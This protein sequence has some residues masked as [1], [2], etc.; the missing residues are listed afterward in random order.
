MRKSASAAQIPAPGDYHNKLP[1]GIKYSILGKP[2]KNDL[3]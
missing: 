1:D 3:E 2:K